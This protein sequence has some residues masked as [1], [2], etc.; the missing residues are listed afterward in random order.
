MTIAT[1]S[2]APS[3]PKMPLPSLPDETLGS[4]HVYSGTWGRAVS[5]RGANVTKATVTGGPE[6]TIG[7]FAHALV[8]ARRAAGLNQSQ[9]AEA[10]GRSTRTLIRWETGD[11][12]PREYVREALVAWLRTV[13]SEHAEHALRALGVLFAPRPEDTP[14]RRSP[15]H[16]RTTRS[17]RSTA[18]FTPLPRE[19]DVRAGRA[20]AVVTAV[21]RSGRSERSRTCSSRVELLA[22]PR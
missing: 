21:A 15:L 5:L 22:V 10:I 8:A 9:L 13:P 20:R 14:R 18:R 2:V 1:G 11:A 7:D 17:S 12:M 19:H 6:V 4:G 3:P 16:S